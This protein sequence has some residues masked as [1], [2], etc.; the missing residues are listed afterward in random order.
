MQNESLVVRNINAKNQL[1]H[2][3]PGLGLLPSHALEWGGDGPGGRGV[4]DKLHCPVQK[5]LFGQ[6]PALLFQ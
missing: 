4:I 5:P 2:K 6:V 1:Q 3:S